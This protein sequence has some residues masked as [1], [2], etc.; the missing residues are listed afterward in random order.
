MSN[1]KQILFNTPMVQ[2]ILD[3][4]KT[5]TRRVVKSPY[6]VDAHGKPM[7]MRPAPKGSYVYRQIG[8]MPYP[9]TPYKSGDILWVRETWAYKPYNNNKIYY[10]ADGEL[11]SLNVERWKPSI[12]MPREAARIFLR[13]TNVRVERLQDI[14]ED[15][16][17]NEGVKDPYDYQ[18]SDYYDQPHMRGIEIN[19]S[20]F[21]GLWDS[22]NA[23]R[24]Y[25]WESNPWV[26]VYEF[27]RTDKQV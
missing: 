11:G 23:K 13:V 3:G 18:N 4:R 14:T 21:A 25:S 9:E 1:P 15:D 2:A 5:M 24:G 27:E 17:L 6:F 20:A 22:I 12:H 26:F 8:M 19:K 7:A 16:A 10:F